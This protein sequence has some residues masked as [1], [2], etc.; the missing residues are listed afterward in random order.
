MKKKYPEAIEKFNKVVSLNEKYSLGYYCLGLCYE[1]TEKAN[2]ALENY[3]N[4][5]L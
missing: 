2:E 1:K 4:L 3:Q 5:F